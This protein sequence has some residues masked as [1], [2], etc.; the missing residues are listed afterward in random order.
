[1]L[2]EHLGLEVIGPLLL[3]ASIVVL[4]LNET[5]TTRQS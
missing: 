4:L 1:V 5:V 3:A 2:A